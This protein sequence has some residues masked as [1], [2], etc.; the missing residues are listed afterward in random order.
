MAIS[1]IPSRRNQQSFARFQEL[2][3]LPKETCATFHNKHMWET[4]SI[5]LKACDN[6]EYLLGLSFVLPKAGEI[7]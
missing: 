5:L 6:L 3:S 2:F 4:A 7:C 1:S